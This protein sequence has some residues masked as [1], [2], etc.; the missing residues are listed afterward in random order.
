LFSRERSPDKSHIKCLPY[1]VN[2]DVDPHKAIA[3]TQGMGLDF[4]KIK[5][6]REASNLS[7]EEAATAAGMGSKQAWSR[8]ENG[9]HTN[10]S[11]ATLEAIA[12][13]LGCSARDLLT[14]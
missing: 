8:I 2:K 6:L 13:A 9:T 12:R 14:K 7:Q 4:E 1:K 3:D 11:I 5:R 10:L